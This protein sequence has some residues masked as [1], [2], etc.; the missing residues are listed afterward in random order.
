MPQSVTD[1]ERVI[2]RTEMNRGQTT[3]LKYLYEADGWVERD[4]IVDEIRW[5][6]HESFVGVLSR[7]E[8]TIPR[9]SL[10]IPDTKR[11]SSG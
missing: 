8:S 10:E 6:D 11:S 9:G 2:R 4:E 5:G 3:L 1:L 7:T